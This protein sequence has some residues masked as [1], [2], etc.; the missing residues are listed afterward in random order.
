MDK[1]LGLEVYVLRVEAEG[2]WIENYH[3]PLTGITP[4][5]MV[6]HQLEGT[7]YTTETVKVEFRDV[8]DNL[9]DDIKSLPNT[10]KLGDKTTPPKQ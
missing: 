9:N 10:G 7:E 3:S 4:L 8:P 5:R 6:M 1:Y 2:Y